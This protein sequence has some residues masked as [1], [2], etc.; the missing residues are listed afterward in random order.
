MRL[1]A[2]AK[3]Q[4]GQGTRRLAVFFLSLL[5]FSHLLDKPWWMQ[6]IAALLTIGSFLL[7][8]KA[9]VLEFT[10]TPRST[11]KNGTNRE[12]NR[13]NKGSRRCP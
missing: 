6:A 12:S 7:A 13:T 1:T 9:A 3:R 5:I 8:W 11:T 4:L 10:N 2:K